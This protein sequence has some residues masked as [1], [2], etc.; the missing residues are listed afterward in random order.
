MHGITFDGIIA[1]ITMYG[2]CHGAWSLIKYL[3][4]QLQTE[5]GRIIHTHVK[6]GHIHRLKHCTIGNC[7]KL[8][9]SL[10]SRET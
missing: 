7:A 6:A 4:R 8:E 1:G 2:I 5:T 10:N 3:Y 9:M